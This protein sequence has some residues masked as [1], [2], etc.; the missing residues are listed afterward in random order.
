MQD[1]YEKAQKRVKDLQDANDKSEIE[2]DVP[3]DANGPIVMNDLF[4][5]GK[6]RGTL[7]MLNKKGTYDDPVSGVRGIG[8]YKN[9]LDTFANTFANEMNKLNGKDKPLFT[10][11]KE[12]DP[13]KLATGITAGNI[14]VAEKWMNNDYNITASTTSDPATGGGPVEGANDNILR[15]IMLFDKDVTYTTKL[16]DGLN[17]AAPTGKPVFKGTF[18]EA[19]TTMQ[20]EFVG[21]KF[22]LDI[23]SGHIA[24]ETVSGIADYEGVWHDGASHFYIDGAVMKTGQIP[25]LAYDE[26]TGK[27][28]EQWPHK[29]SL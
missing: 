18:E 10:N 8:Y 22:A 23:I 9:M 25:V 20:P 1:A 15:F 3:T 21:Q 16:D 6:L 4:T 28:W 29:R 27:Y 12:T 7:E 11:S 13:T 14:R 19:F 5:D 17:G 2:G 24:T 26:S